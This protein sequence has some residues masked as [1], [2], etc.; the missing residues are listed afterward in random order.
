LDHGFAIADAKC[1]GSRSF[2]N[3]NP[4]LLSPYI[5]NIAKQSK[6]FILSS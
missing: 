6:L 2:L 5:G 4:F 1:C 3:E